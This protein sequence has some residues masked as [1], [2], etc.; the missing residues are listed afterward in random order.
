[1]TSLSVI[2]ERIIRNNILLDD[3]GLHSTHRSDIP[4]F[5]CSVRLPHLQRLSITGNVYIFD[6][7][8]TTQSRSQMFTTFLTRHHKLKYLRLTGPTAAPITPTTVE[9]LP[10]LCS[11]QLPTYSCNPTVIPFSIATGLT[12][13]ATAYLRE[14]HD[15]RADIFRV[16]EEAK[17]LRSIVARLSDE[18]S[19]KK[20]VAVN[21][22]LEKVYFTPDL[23][24]WGYAVGNM[25]CQRLGI[26]N[27]IWQ[28]ISPEAAKSIFSL[29]A[30]LPHLTH[31]GGLNILVQAPFDGLDAMLQHLSGHTK[32][33][34]MEVWDLTQ[35][36]KSNCL[37]VE[38]NEDGSYKG[39]KFTD[40]VR[41]F[42]YG[43]WGGLF[44][45]LA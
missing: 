42:R 44:D 23:E 27:D 31:I 13:I 2:L 38:R 7:Y 22:L 32:L 5:Y 20:I 17:E 25:F 40:S 26:D 12:H 3:L 33:L 21:P 8:L 24:Q 37:E 9:T 45:G 39:W 41:P 6:R 14:E 30:E 36:A 15:P 43:G 18:K 19:L 11:I 1:M 4:D 34:Y 29:L 28:A 16:L 10:P 35:T